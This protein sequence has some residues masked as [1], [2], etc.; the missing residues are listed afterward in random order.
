MFKNHMKIALRNFYKHKIFSFINV[1][2]LAI[3]MA[4]CMLIMLWVQDE[5]N[6]E[7]FNANIDDIFC[8]VN[9]WSNNPNSSSSSIPAPLI[10]YLKDKY[11]EIQHASRF[12]VSGRRLFSYNE[13]N[14][15]EDNGGFADPELFD[16]FSFKA[17]LSDPKAAL[18]D[19]NTIILTKSMAE[20]Y[21]G[22]E[23]P[24]GKT[25]KLENQYLFSVG[26]IIEDIP[27]NSSI[28]FD[29]L[30]PFE[31]FGRFS[32]VGMD[33]WRRR[34]NY[35]GFVILY[36]N[37]DHEAFSEKIVNEIVN[38]DPGATARLKL[39]PYKDLRLFGLNNN[40]TFKFVLVFSTIAIL[41]LLIA[42]INF[43]NLTT[44]QSGKRAKEIGL[45]KVIGASKSSIKRQI[46]TELVAIVTIAFILSVAL[47]DL[48]NFRN[49]SCFQFIFFFPC[50]SYEAG[51]SNRIKQV[52]LK[53][54]TGHCSVCDFNRSDHF[55]SHYYSTDDLYKK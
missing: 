24:L 51:D 43:V 13:S 48:D 38:N 21:F 17:V 3:G 9:Y 20:K 25:I 5:L 34:E 6:Y 39:F 40:G 8:V 28:R 50:K 19:I 54:T 16:I 4:C 27:R 23:D 1:S 2:G 53:K 7:K 44:A 18:K 52:F 33:N 45:R 55:D 32:Q 35:N 49:L 11:P 15:F 36:D 41:I 22:S 46:Y 30:M 42:C 12:R 26:A 37:V 47:V 31:N 29:Y 10:P 14:V